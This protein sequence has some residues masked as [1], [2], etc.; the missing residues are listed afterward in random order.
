MRSRKYGIQPIPPSDSAIL[1]PGN[2]VKISEK[3]SS[4]AQ[5]NSVMGVAAIMI[6]IGAVRSCR[7]RRVPEPMWMQT[8]VPSSEQA[9]QN[10]SQWSL[11]RL[12]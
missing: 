4:V 8:I 5:L 2:F 12:G 3:T 1:T 9:F 6:S 11:C 10:G 7:F